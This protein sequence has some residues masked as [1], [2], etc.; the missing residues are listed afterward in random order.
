MPVLKTLVETA[1]KARFKAAAKARK[2]TE[3]GLLRS[4]VLSVI[5]QDQGAEQAVKAEPGQSEKERMTV[6]LP[7]FLMSAIDSRAKAKSMKPSRWVS[8]LVQSNLMKQ[9]VMAEAELNAL[10]TSNRELAAIGRNINQIAKQLNQAFYEAEKFHLDELGR[11][12]KQIEQNR[13]AILALVQASQGAW[14]AD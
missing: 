1:I 7:R 2:R 13:A 12:G 8:A 4:L 14:E 5:D 6:R 11:L 9:P 10:L 3:A